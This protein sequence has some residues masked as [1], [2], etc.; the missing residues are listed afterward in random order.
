MRYSI[1]A[2]ISGAAVMVAEIA[3]ARAIAPH[4]GTSIIV[5]TNVIGIILIALALGYWIGGRLAERRPD[6]RALGAIVLLAGVFLIIPAFAT[7]LIAVSL[8]ETLRGAESGFLVLLLG[9][10]LSVVVLFALP[11][12]LLGMVSPFLV[13]LACEES[14]QHRMLDRVSNIECRT[15]RMGVGVIA[16]RLY[17][18]STIG[19]LVGTFLPTLVLLP[20]IGTRRTILGAA[21]ALVLLGVSLMRRRSMI[22][23]AFI[24]LALLAWPEQP[25]PWF[26]GGRVVAA[27]ESPYQYLRIIDS[28]DSRF[29]VFNEGFGVQSVAVDPE[30]LPDGYFAAIAALPALVF[31]QGKPLRDPVRVLILGNAGGT[32]GHLTQRRFPNRELDITGVEIDPAVTALTATHFP[33]PPHPYPIVHT[34]SRTFVRSASE[35]YD[36]IVVDAYTNQLTIPPH[37]VT[38]E[39]YALLRPRLAPGG[40]V[41]ANVNAP[42]EDS[43][44]FRMMTQTVADAFPYVVEGSVGAWNRL[45]IASDSAVN[46]DRLR[47][48]EGALGEFL[49]SMRPVRRDRALRIFADDWAPIELMTDIEI[50]DALQRT[51]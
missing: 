15:D 48:T 27:A 49:R 2:F 36:V 41:V 45:I 33:P 24:P 29:L 9:S 8:I 23:V 44:L 21:A 32:I 4:F 26:L 42:R 14:V 17:A 25:L 7:S 22:V 11:I 34:D 20:M 30:R 50:F 6:V 31:S 1:I 5:W 3:A 12:F 51:R 38:R 35:Q 16:G 46:F 47:D 19:S 39:F 43:R 13:K 37:L 40:I 10:F 18:I 28:G